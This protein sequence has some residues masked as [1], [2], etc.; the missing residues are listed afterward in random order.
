MKVSE[1]LKSE[2]GFLISKLSI[3]IQKDLEIGL[4]DFGIRLKQYAIL[5]LIEGN[6]K[7]NQRAV[8]EILLLDRNTVVHFIDDLEKKRIFRKKE[9]P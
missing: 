7:F 8:G 6:S 3:L 4:A 5:Q 9:K 1:N 2:N